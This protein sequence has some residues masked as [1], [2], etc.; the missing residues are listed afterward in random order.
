ME[1]VNRE[2]LDVPL[3]PG[4]SFSTYKGVTSPALVSLDFSL[5][6]LPDSWA[7]PQNPSQPLI[8]GREKDT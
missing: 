1:W 7:S 8:S 4:T 5:F 3:S 2:G 6:L